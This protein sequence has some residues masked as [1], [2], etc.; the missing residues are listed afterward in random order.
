MDQPFLWHLFKVFGRVRDIYLSAANPRRKIGISFV[1]FETLDEA[2]RVAEQT[3]GMHV[4]GWPIRTK[5]AQ[6]G[7]TDRRSMKVGD[8]VPQRVHTGKEDKADRWE[9]RQRH[10]KNSSYMDVLKVGSNAREDGGE[11]SSGSSELVITNTGVADK[12]WLYNSAIGVLRSFSNVSKVRRRLL[13]RGFSFSARFLGGRAIL[14]SFE[15]IHECEGFIRNSFFWKDM[16]CSMEKWSE[17]RNF[18]DMPCWFSLTGIALD[19]WNEKFFHKVGSKLGDLLL[20]DKESILRQRLDTARML[21]L[22]SPN[23]TVQKEIKVVDGSRFFSVSVER[24]VSLNDSSWIMDLLGLQLGFERVER[25]C[26]SSPD[27]SQERNQEGR[28]A[29]TALEL[30]SNQ[31][32]G[33]RSMEPRESNLKGR[34]GGVG[35]EDGIKDTFRQDR[36]PI[37]SGGFVKRVVDRGKSVKGLK[38]RKFQTSFSNLTGKLIIGKART[39]NCNKWSTEERSSSSSDDNAE[40]GQYFHSVRF[41]GE[42]SKNQK[43]QEWANDD[44]LRENSKGPQC[45]DIEKMNM[46]S[47]SDENPMKAH[48]EGMGLLLTKSPRNVEVSQRP[49]KEPGEGTNSIPSLQ[50]EEGSWQNIRIQVRPTQTR[51]FPVEDTSIGDVT[52]GA[53]PMQKRR[54]RPQRLCMSTRS[55]KK[56]VKKRGSKEGEPGSAV[57]VDTNTDW[58]LDDEVAKVTE[59]AALRGY[60][61]RNF[62]FTKL[63]SKHSKDSG[64]G[65]G[66]E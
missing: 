66:A 25:E 15:S 63:V 4:F 30:M 8:G 54:G 2:R 39:D 17:V 49:L 24:E 57:D 45:L 44:G 47:C 27:T 40:V 61:L 31:G 26:L 42:N 43:I 12:Q 9:N 5:V 59:K 65:N 6:N 55:S 36:S 10:W 28:R 34:G 33:R 46:G 64:E 38:P 41:R 51:T 18:E 60:N 29:E 16:F 37:K 56:G 11:A 22:V 53:K 1:R 14:W 23:Q 19:Y 32:L 21:I 62:D 7:W 20:V 50:L 52:V 13:S 35:Q 48:S 3:N 58:N